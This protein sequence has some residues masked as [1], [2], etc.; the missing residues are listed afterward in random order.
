MPLYNY[1]YYELIIVKHELEKSLIKT[2]T[3]SPHTNQKFI[4]LG[5]P[6]NSLFATS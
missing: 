2:A 1:S 5:E 3:T 6:K 4:L